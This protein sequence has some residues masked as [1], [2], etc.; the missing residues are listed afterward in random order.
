MPDDIWA[1]IKPLTFISAVVLYVLLKRHFNR[2]QAN[3]RLEDA[4]YLAQIAMQH[5]C[6]EYDLFHECGRNW[7]LGTS[8]I[9]EDFETY[10]RNYDIPHYVRDFIRKKRNM[11]EDTDPPPRDPGGKLPPSWSA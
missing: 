8:R 1:L 7:N 4:E 11:A 5:K 6:S 2:K 10:L 3:R 9:E